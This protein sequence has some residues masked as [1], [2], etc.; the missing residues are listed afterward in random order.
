[1]VIVKRLRGAAILA[2]AVGAAAVL[3][4]RTE[5]QGN[6][7]QVLDQMAQDTE[8]F[9]NQLNRDAAGVVGD[10]AIGPALKEAR[11]LVA[12]KVPTPES[13]RLAREVE[14]TLDSWEKVVKAFGASLEDMARCLK[15]SESGCFMR[16][17]GRQTEAM[18]YW[19]QALADQGTQAAIARVERMSKLVNDYV[20]RLGTNAVT[21]TSMGAGC[22]AQVIDRAPPPPAPPVTAT[23]RAPAPPPPVKPADRPAP[24]ETPETVAQS[25]GGHLGTIVLLGGL[26]SLG[27]VAYEYA[28]KHQDQQNC[29]ASLPP[30]TSCQQN[31]ASS[32]CS[33]VL[34][35][36]DDYCKCH[37]Y[38]GFATGSAYS[39]SAS[40]GCYR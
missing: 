28:Q 14:G 16:I 40:A 35:E 13:A 30:L 17:V 7:D 39:Y 24:A 3:L 18:R 12:E 23:T 29:P 32:A 9:R 6:C 27:V 37:G 22:V 15:S 21:H 10:E 4:Q 2:F 20:S 5:A 8:A 38:A 19:M 1:M 26:G 36:A 25:G 31:P 34:S 11:R 33:A